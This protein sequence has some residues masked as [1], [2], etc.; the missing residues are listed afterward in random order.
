MLRAGFSSAPA[1]GVNLGL[2][3]CKVLASIARMRGVFDWTLSLARLAWS[4]IVLGLYCGPVVA[5]ELVIENVTAV[6]A[7]RSEPMRNVTVAVRDGRIVSISHYSSAQA[8]TAAQDREV[9][10]GRGLYL[11]PGLID[12]HVHTDQV[13]GMTPQH[14]AAHPDI[15]R[16]ARAQNPRSYLYFGFTTLIDLIS[17]PEAIE[18]WNRQPEHPDIYFCGATPIVDGYPMVWAPK[19]ERYQQ[20][21]YLIVQ[22]GEEATAPEGIDPVAH[23]PDAVVERMKRDGASCV[24]TF[25]ERGEAGKWPIP[26]LE[27]IRALVNA[28][29]RAQLPVL[30]HATS[31]EAQEFALDAGV[32]IIAHGLWSWTGDP[33]T[34]KLTPRVIKVLNRIVKARVAWQPTMQVSYGFRDMFDPDSL[35][36]PQLTHV[37]P[38]SSI[39]WYRTPE[40]QWFRDTIAR[41]LPKETLQGDAPDQWQRVRAFYQQTIARNANVTHYLAEHHARLLFGTDTPSS[42]LYTN[43]PGLNGWR[44]MNRLVEAGLTPAQVFRA[45]TLAN[46]QALGLES[47]IGTVQVGK[48][49][50]LLLLRNDPTRSI[51][52]YDQIVKVILNGRVL[53]RSALSATGGAG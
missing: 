32:D 37:L 42:P 33:D 11:S 2:Q 28:A 48:R 27:T 44:E 34:S 31:T 19:P 49:A 45:A 46:A 15:A 43:P 26:R 39:A 24:K 38:A 51:Q 20:F 5:R 25:Y 35:A 12:S 8:A 1:S 14:E 47:E 41:S 29:H 36:D 53:E 3:D 40:G 7:E 13:H 52:A 23:T 9:I 16:A 17:V 18:R 50:N 22:R 21:P 6:S 30:I 4:L 10:D